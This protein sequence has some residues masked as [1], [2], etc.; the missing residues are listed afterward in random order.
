MENCFSCRNWFPWLSSR[1][2]SSTSEVTLR[3]SSIASSRANASAAAVNPTWRHSNPDSHYGFRQPP[4]AGRYQLPNSGT[5]PADLSHYSAIPSGTI[6]HFHFLLDAVEGMV[7]SHISP[8][9]YLP[10]SEAHI[11]PFSN[12]GFISP[13]NF[14]YQGS[15]SPPIFLD[16]CLQG[17]ISPPTF[18]LANMT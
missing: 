18:I 10:L 9:S 11:S 14:W 3:P 4:A 2:A 1:I 13:P 17:I 6:F 8:Y 15:I 7:R 16:F 5:T 12:Q